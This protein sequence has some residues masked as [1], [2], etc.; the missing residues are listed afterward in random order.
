[1]NFL[2]GV[3]VAS[4]GCFALVRAEEAVVWERESFPLGVMA[5]GLA[6]ADVNGDQR[7]DFLAATGDGAHL[8]L[9]PDFRPERVFDS[10]GQRFIHVST[11]DADQDGDADFV[12]GSFHN[13][14]GYH[15]KKLSEGRE[16][17][18]P[19]TPPRTLVW[20]ENTGDPANWPLHVLDGDSNQCH[21]TFAADLN[22]DGIED[23]LANSVGGQVEWNDTLFWH[24]G[25]FR[26]GE[27]PA[28]RRHVAGKGNAKG[29][30]HY[31]EVVD[32]DGDGKQEVLLTAPSAGR[33][34]VWHPGEDP[35][36][37]WTQETL[38]EK[39][40]ITNVVQADVDGDGAIDLIISCGHGTGISWLKRPDWREHVI[41]DQILDVHALATADFN[42]DGKPDVAGISNKTE[43]AFWYENLGDGNF[44]KHP[45]AP[46]A[47][48]QAYELRAV[49]VDGDGRPDLVGAGLATENVFRYRNAGQS[50][51]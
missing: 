17:R 23:I 29:R 47:S 32:L 36:Q 46:G 38:F 45:I 24:E 25:P 4:L 6:V 26:P 33:L 35:T 18:E 14:W 10:G 5:Q 43:E 40:G 9:A 27:A 42:A 39:P 30:S 19:E 15:A 51:P 20:L 31:F 37:P 44:R 3:L 22:G 28:T 12:L 34:N 49:D 1:M 48:Q 8:L 41:D 11:M 16:S 21:G 7:P 13:P 50:V 2:R